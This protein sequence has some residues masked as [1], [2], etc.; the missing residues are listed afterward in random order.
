[1]F[2]IET[3]IY[4]LSNVEFYLIRSELLSAK[5]C[6]LTGQGAYLT[7]KH[8]PLWQSV[9]RALFLA[10]NSKTKLAIISRICK[11]SLISLN[12]T[13]NE[14]NHVSIEYAKKRNSY[15]KISRANDDEQS[16]NDPWAR[17]GTFHIQI[18]DS[19]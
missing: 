1:M 9:L 12:K 19:D 5:A 13:F 7:G 17:N 18:C 11:E 2:T 4:A 15:L 14:F 8:Q 6:C 16:H 10:T 3:Y